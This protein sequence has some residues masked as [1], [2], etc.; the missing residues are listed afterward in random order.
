MFY[1]KTDQQIYNLGNSYEPIT[2]LG[3][4]NKIGKVLNKKLKIKMNKNFVDNSDRSKER[5]I[6]YRYCN[7]SK[8]DRVIGWRPLINLNQGIKIITNFYQK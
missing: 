1:K 2:L 4:A 5:E 6:Y 7:S 8:L 3:L